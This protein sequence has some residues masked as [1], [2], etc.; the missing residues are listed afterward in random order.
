[1]STKPNAP[2]QRRRLEPADPRP[3]PA[4]HLPASRR[5][6]PP[7]HALPETARARRLRLV[8]DRARIGTPC[9]RRRCGARGTR[10][11]GPD[12]PVPEEGMTPR[13]YVDEETGR[14]YY[15]RASYAHAVQTK[16][17]ANNNATDKERQRLTRLG[18]HPA[19]INRM[20]GEAKA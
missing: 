14:V 6:V 4:R 7:H 20:L 2:P 3:D 1:S 11:D 5:R 17:R 10:P 12:A 16:T 15:S 8:H 19:Q 13:P 9:R 18:V